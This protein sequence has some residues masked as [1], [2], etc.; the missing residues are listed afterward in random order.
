MKRVKEEKKR[1]KGESIY[2]VKEIGVT[3]VFIISST[4]VS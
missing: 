2:E 4:Q 3:Y 1:E